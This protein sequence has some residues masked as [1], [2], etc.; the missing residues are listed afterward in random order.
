MTYPIASELLHKDEA[1]ID[2]LSDLSGCPWGIDFDWRRACRK[3][4]GKRRRQR[5]SGMA[6]CGTHAMLYYVISYYVISYY[7][8]PYC[9]IYIYIYIYI[10]THTYIYIYICMYIYMYIYILC[11]VIRGWPVLNQHTVVH[12]RPWYTG[13]DNVW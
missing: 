9:N 5:A 7:V 4:P 8:I 6:R 11:K 13:G 1:N 2:P 10:H 12:D 3:A